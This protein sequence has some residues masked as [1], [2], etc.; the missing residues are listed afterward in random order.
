MGRGFSRREMLIGSF[1]GAALLGS[2]LLPGIYA[3]EPNGVVPP[4]HDHSGEAP[5]MPVAIE[6][7]P[8]YEPALVRGK[9]DAALD[10]IGGIGKLV[11]DKTVTVKVNMTGPVR[12]LGGLPASRT[13]HVHPNV[14][15]A[16]CAALHEAGARRIAVVEA[17]YY[18]DPVEKIL[19]LA[20]WDLSAIQSAAGHKVVFENTK[21]R[22]SWPR[23]SRLQVP[24]GG[25]LFPAFDLNGWYDKT[26]VMVS[27]SK[28]KQHGTAG[29]T[30]A[31]KNMFGITPTALYGNDA[32]KED[33]VAARVLLI[34][35]AERSV[36]EG[37]PG[38]IDR[39]IPR[40][41]GY[42]VPR[43]TADL[44]GARPI[45]LCVIDGI[46]TIRGGEGFWNEGVVPLQPKLLLVGRN[47]VC[48]DAICTA[49]MGFDPTVAHNRPPFQG[50]NH[51]RL[52]AE[53][54]VGTNDPARIE[55][56][57]VPL[58]KAVFPFQTRHTQR[59]NAVACPGHCP[60]A[61]P[62]RYPERTDYCFDWPR[63]ST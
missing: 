2:R 41:A 15:A 18:T 11:R 49:A 34:H 45:D 58:K 47:P 32:P 8:S 38:E 54:G 19:Q 4:L 55:I 60:I 57:G 17:L 59:G 53:A 1:G 31:S 6:Q 21:N 27:L 12:E 51:L 36:P 23:Y 37:V 25:Y 52:L 16:V 29:V 48:T 30:M 63:N 44:V 22:G 39:G 10:L 43:V 26:D 13:Y 24:W 46:D 42:R 7:C 33:T 14:V 20:G 50:E 3:A 28:L 62:G 40:E 56:R 9:L 35:F 61:T 5:S